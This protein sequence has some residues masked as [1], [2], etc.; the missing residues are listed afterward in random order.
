[1]KRNDKRD[2]YTWVEIYILKIV[3]KE[4][5]RS[6]MLR[7]MTLTCV[8]AIVAGLAAWAIALITVT[9]N[10]LE[11]YNL[12]ENARLLCRSILFF[13]GFFASLAAMAITIQL[14]ATI[15]YLLGWLTYREYQICCRLGL[16]YSFFEQDDADKESDRIGSGD[17]TSPE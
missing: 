13:S 11:P 1:M 9:N 15:S 8:L 10:I 7:F 4:K 12:E 5:W 6:D 14:S 3:I 16:P 2:H 17:I